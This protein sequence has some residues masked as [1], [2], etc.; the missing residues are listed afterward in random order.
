M[1]NRSNIDYLKNLNSLGEADFLKIISIE[2]SV[3][4]ELS[5][6]QDSLGPDFVLLSKIVKPEANVNINK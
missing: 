4:L 3:I 1:T 6:D 2:Y 5:G